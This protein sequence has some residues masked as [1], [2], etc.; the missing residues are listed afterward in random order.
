MFNIFFV[1]KQGFR[2]GFFAI[3]CYR[4]TIRGFNEQPTFNKQM[5]HLGESIDLK[6]VLGY[7]LVKC[8]P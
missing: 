7:I 4:L 8:P 1:L 6:Q 5:Q 2:S 3:N